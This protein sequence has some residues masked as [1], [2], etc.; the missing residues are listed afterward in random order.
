M[1]N[2]L[3]LAPNMLNFKLKAQWGKCVMLRASLKF[4]FAFG[5]IYWLVSS[6]KLDFKLFLMSWQNGPQI[7][8]A[9]VAVAFI[10]I[11][12]GLRWKM[13]L[14]VKATKKI[15]MKKIIPI[16]W[17]GVFFSTFLPGAVTGDILKLLYVKDLDSNF[18][19]T[20]LLTSV[21]ID[22][23]IGLCGLLTLSGLVSVFYYKELV[24][25]G[26]MI[27]H[28]IHF[29]LLLALGSLGLISLLFIPEKYNSKVI[30][31]MQKVPVLGSKLS[32][33]LEQTWAFNGHHKKIFGCI[34]LSLFIQ[35]INILTF[36]ILTKPFYTS[37]I[38]IAHVFSIVP[39]GFIS[40][41]IPIS[42][43]GAGVGHLA[44]NELFSMYQISGGASLFNIF[45]LCNIITNLIGF[46]PYITSRKKHTLDEAHV[47]ETN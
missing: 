27:A 7:L 20:F 40:T 47:F 32:H 35:V 30:A 3:I 8:F 43:A 12:T 11:L 16:H 34:L 23:V 5:M 25:H 26:P 17:I 38:S 37:P 24:E 9:M 22:R 6:G 46:F 15:S 13:L 31:L 45:F 29:N 33:F 36:Y 19:K 42:P 28:M 21:L 10:I 39:I 1:I 4:I 2:G 44:F 14:D 18:N 41:A